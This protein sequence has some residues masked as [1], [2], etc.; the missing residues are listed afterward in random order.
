MP[1]SLKIFGT[2]TIRSGGAL[3]S[4]IFGLS[5]NTKVFT[6]IIYFAR[7][8]YQKNLKLKN[9]NELY[10]IANEISNRIF[11]RNNL[12]IP[13]SNFYYHFANSKIENFSDFYNR[14]I[15]TFLENTSQNNKKVVLE[16]SSGEW[17][18]IDKFL[19]MNKNH[20]A[21]HI[22][23]DPRAI[24]SSFKKITFGKGYEYLFPIFNWMDSYNH[25]LK[26][27]KKFNSDRYLFLQFESLHKEPLI[28]VKKILDFANLKFYNKYLSNTFWKKKLSESK[29]YV[30][31]SAYDQNKKY[32]FDIKRINNWRGNLENWEISLIQNLLGDTMEKLGYNR[33]RLKNDNQLFKKGLKNIKSVSIFR[34]RL[35]NLLEFNL[36]SDLRVIDPKN[37]ANWSSSY[38]PKKKFIYDKEY[39]FFINNVKNL[40]K[41]TNK[42]IIKKR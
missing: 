42:I 18:F 10:F 27:Q 20:K 15:L 8:I 13:A 40:K 5:N 3:T 34:K 33:I 19:N 9:L 7:H 37:P 35:S 23:R 41:L 26:Y 11:F 2:G 29:D 6:D 21:F 31:F 38:N 30:N 4:N 1:A 32:G 36:G 39:K 28:S 16:Y 24:I 14:I 25:Y 17:R 22:I 12:Y